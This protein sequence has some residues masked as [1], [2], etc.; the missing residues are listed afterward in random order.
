MLAGRPPQVAASA[1]SPVGTTVLTALTWAVGTAVPTALTWAVGTA[2][3]T[4]LGESHQTI[5]R[6][7]APQVVHLD[8]LAR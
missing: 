2:V 3:P 5:G 6:D 7:A 8:Q 4:A 1:H